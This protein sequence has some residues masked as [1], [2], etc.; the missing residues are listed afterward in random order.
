L[1]FYRLPELLRAEL[2]LELHV[3]LKFQLLFRVIIFLELQRGLKFQWKFRAKPLPEP[4]EL[5]ELLELPKCNRCKANDEMELTETEK[6]ILLLALDPGAAEGEVSAA[7][8]KLIRLSGS[9][10]IVGTTSSGT[11]V[12]CLR[13]PRAYPLFPRDLPLGA[14]ERKSTARWSCGS[15]STQ[16]NP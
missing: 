3:I 16:A 11:W 15:E 7:A 4:L 5:Q 8:T 13:A 10:T 1:K 14:S 12:R 2:L 6:K 9:G